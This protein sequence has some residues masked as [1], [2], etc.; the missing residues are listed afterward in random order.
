MVMRKEVGGQR[1]S[2]SLCAPRR[3]L[4]FDHFLFFSSGAQQEEEQL[5]VYCMSYV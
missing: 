3:D 2:F 4:V 5:L 1:L